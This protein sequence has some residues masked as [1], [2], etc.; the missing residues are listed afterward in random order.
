M[1]FVLL[2]LMYGSQLNLSKSGWSGHRPDVTTVS[3]QLSILCVQYRLFQRMAVF[4]RSVTVSV[5]VQ[6][7]G[8]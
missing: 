5:D 7:M 8:G 6:N 4:A 2:Q 1:G 3:V